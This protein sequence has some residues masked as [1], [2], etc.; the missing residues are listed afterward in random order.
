MFPAT[1]IALLSFLIG[2]CV[3]VS[4]EDPPEEED[5]GEREQR[6]QEIRE[7]SCPDPE[8]EANEERGWLDRTHARLT[9]SLCEPAVW[10]DGFFGETR[11]L[12]QNP[13]STFVRWRNEVR[14]GENEGWRYRL[15]LNGNVILPRVSERIR[16]IISRDEDVRGEFDDGPTVEPSEERTRLG[17]RYIAR[18]RP[19]SSLDFDG[20]IKWDLPLNP[21]VSARYR[22]TYPLAERQR[23]RW[24]QEAFWERDD[25]F[26]TTSRL[27]WEW[28]PDPGSLLRW[29]GRGKYS[30]VSNGVDWNSSV[31]WYKQLSMTHA[32]RAEAGAVGWT[33]PDLHVEEYFV[34]FRYRRRWLRDWLYYELQPEYAWV[35]EE[36]AAS[37]DG[38]WRITFTLEIQFET[39]KG[40]YRPDRI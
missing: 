17:L 29:T 19:R 36:G 34:N 3:V 25:G 4:A 33:R 14:W 32:V 31:T 6:R 13:V 20:G 15:R 8:E 12:E 22:Y 16:L 24:T 30:E 2:F 27:D 18:D 7:I 11:A 40:A 28:Q 10:F 37:R 5:A 26:G 21:F 39:L 1:R 23:A 38:R 9:Y 35:K